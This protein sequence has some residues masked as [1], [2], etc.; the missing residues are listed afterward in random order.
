MRINTERCMGCGNCIKAC[1]KQLL[2][3]GEQKNEGGYY[4]LVNMNPESC[5]NCGECELMCTADA[6]IARNEPSPINIPSIK[7]IHPGCNFGVLRRVYTDIISKMNIQDELVVF[8]QQGSNI[9][10]NI[11]FREYGHHDEQYYE[12][13]LK[14]KKE[15]PEKLVVLQ[16]PTVYEA[17]IEK[18]RQR[19]IALRDENVT[20]LNTNMYFNA[21]EDFTQMTSGGIDTLEEVNELGYASFIARGN[22]RS[23][24]NVRQ[25]EK[26][27]EKAL[28][29]QRN[30]QS[31][32]ILELDVPCY[33][34]LTNR[35]KEIM[36]AEKVTQIS[37]WFEENV[38]SIYDSRIIKE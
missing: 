7:P 17:D 36:R 31:F 3:I 13:A 11:D 18:N 29:N 10:L 1:P 14:Y 37:Q 16:I 19:F 33:Y 2:K 23:T 20:L 25:F 21:D 6:I 9:G 5:V 32:S 15:H 26:F 28:L 4:Y 8:T 34:L 22:L 35:N 30:N 12:D 24:K 38:I 27:F